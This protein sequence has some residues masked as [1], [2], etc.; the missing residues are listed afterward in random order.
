MTVG[1]FDHSGRHKLEYVRSHV[2]SSKGRY[3]LFLLYC[4]C[5]GRCQWLTATRGPP[6][7]RP[8]GRERWMGLLCVA[9]RRRCTTLEPPPPLFFFSPYFTLQHLTNITLSQTIIHH[10]A[11]ALRAI[12]RIIDIDTQKNIEEQY[13]RQ[14][15]VSLCASIHSITPWI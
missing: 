14:Y 13:R 15:D 3:D 7:V 2:W 11:V 10:L 1:N 4:R 5:Y 9:A 6:A 12:K 8:E